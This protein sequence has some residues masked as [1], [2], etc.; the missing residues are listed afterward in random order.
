M[1][2]VFTRLNCIR[3]T[4]ILCNSFHVPILLFPTLFSCLSF[5]CFTSDFLHLK[6]FF[7]FKSVCLSSL[8]ENKIILFKGPFH[9][10][11]YLYI[12]L[13]VVVTRNNLKV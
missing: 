9:F 11:S 2:S 12:I 3:V 8:V 4:L 7:F 1:S 6:V 10:M 5:F 13:A